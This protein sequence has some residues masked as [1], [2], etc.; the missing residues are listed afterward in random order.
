M[1]EAIVKFTAPDSITKYV[2][3]GVSMND[4][5]GMGLP[6]LK[7][8]LRVFLSFFIQANLPNQI[9]R[10]EVLMQDIVI[11]NYLSNTQNVIVSVKRNDN[12]FVV[13]TPEFDGWKS[14]LI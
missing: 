3:S 1:G 5:F 11:F 6:G 2:F 14:N 13:L 8:E 4:K 9:K 7:P 12:Q 10:G